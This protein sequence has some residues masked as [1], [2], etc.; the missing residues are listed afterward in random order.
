MLYGQEKNISAQFY[1]DSSL[2]C[3]TLSKAIETQLKLHQ[4][5]TGEVSRTVKI[6]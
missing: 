2:Q 4:Y 1:R 5:G 6:E 3:S